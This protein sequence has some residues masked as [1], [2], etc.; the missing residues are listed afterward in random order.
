MRT[1][2]STKVCSRSTHE[3]FE[4]GDAA[5]SRA[6]HVA[7]A[8]VGHEREFRIA[9]PGDDEPSLLD[10]LLELVSAARRVA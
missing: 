3:S 1:L 7:N 2:P 6:R 4:H 9:Q 10:T 8:E 5:D